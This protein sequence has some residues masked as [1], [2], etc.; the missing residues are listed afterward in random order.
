LAYEF[1][2]LMN[3]YKKYFKQVSSYN[4]I[5]LFLIFLTFY[6]LSI[7]QPDQ[8]YALKSI[9]SVIVIS[10]FIKLVNLIEVWSKLSFVVRML[11][12]AFI[13]LILFLIFFLIVIG[14]MTLIA[15]I[16]LVTPEDH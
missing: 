6:L 16:V 15:Q 7:Y 5:F 14:A 13:N 4:N 3:T 1:L 11:F 12:K 8:V 2:K 9:Q 10:A